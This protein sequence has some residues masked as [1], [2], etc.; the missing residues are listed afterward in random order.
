MAAE[1][2]TNQSLVVDESLRQSTVTFEHLFTSS[3]YNISFV[4]L[5]ILGAL[6]LD[7]HQTHPEGLFFLKAMQIS[8]RPYL[9][10]VAPY[11]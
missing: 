2:L 1:D 11:A 6:R 4:C 9:N 10:R 5:A 7:H 3:I 8:I